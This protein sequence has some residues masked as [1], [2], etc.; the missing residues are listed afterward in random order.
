[1]KHKKPNYLHIQKRK[2]LPLLIREA[3]DTAVLEA[4]MVRS[5]DITAAESLVEEG[6]AKDIRDAFIQ[7]REAM[8]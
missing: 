3:G 4:L 2:P 7:I 5:L 6:K 8:L 1:M